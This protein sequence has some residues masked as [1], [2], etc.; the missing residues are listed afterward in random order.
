M[1]PIFLVVLI[2]VT[3]I[4][5]FGS[6]LLKLKNTHTLNPVEQ[7]TAMWNDGTDAFYKQVLS[8][9]GEWVENAGTPIF[10]NQTVVTL[11]PRLALGNTDSKVLGVN[12]NIAVDGSEKWIDV[13]LSEQ[14][15]RAFEGNRLIYEF[16][17]SSGRSGYDTVKGEF[18]VWSKVRNQSYRGGSKERGDYY[19]LPNVPYS[20]FFYKGYA[21]HGAY[22]HNDFGIKRRSSGC[23]NLRIP[24]AEKIY[25]WAGPAMPD[26]IGAVNATNDNPGV[27]VVV[28]D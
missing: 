4:L 16:P 14:K 1:R 18:R 2:L 20:L 25:N 6:N 22:W 21:I 7:K 23:V 15:L 5:L 19:Y 26:G 12:M 24:D 8:S 28:H 10:D 11:P 17:I 13:S 9:N 3:L 27:R